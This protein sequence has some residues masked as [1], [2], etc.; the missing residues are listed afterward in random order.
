MSAARPAWSRLKGWHPEKAQ[1][2]Y[3]RNSPLTFGN[4][5]PGSAIRYCK[6]SQLHSPSPKPGAV[7]AKKT[8]N[9]YTPPSATRSHHHFTVTP[10]VF[11]GICLAV[12]LLP[13]LA[14]TSIQRFGPT[15]WAQLFSTVA[16]WLWMMSAVMAMGILMLCGLMWR[17]GAD[18]LQ[19]MG[20]RL[21]EF[22]SRHRARPMALLITA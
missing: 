11:F 18:W 3:R 6:V 4:Y 8:L 17:T 19:E 10:L 7:D 9:F 13:L 16:A 12:A 1:G 5:L 21:S 20:A 15:G 14:L 22:V 2:C